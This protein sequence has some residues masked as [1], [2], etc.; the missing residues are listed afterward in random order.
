[1]PHMYGEQ[2]QRSLHPQTRDAGC[3]PHWQL[4]PMLPMRRYS[5]TVFCQ[6]V[7]SS[8]CSLQL[9]PGCASHYYLWIR[10]GSG[11]RSRMVRHVAEG[12]LQQR[13]PALQ[14]IQ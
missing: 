8:S 10:Q 2:L 3:Y 13:A 1:M 6:T 4:P 12:K 5:C 14:E 11:H 9:S 7:L